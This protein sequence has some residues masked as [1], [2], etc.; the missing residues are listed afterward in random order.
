MSIMYK[1]VGIVF[2]V[3]NPITVE[4]DEKYKVVLFLESKPMKYDVLKEVT[5]WLFVV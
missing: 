2:F 4:V 1:I 3:K 5:C